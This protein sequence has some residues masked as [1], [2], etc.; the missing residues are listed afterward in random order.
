MISSAST[1]VV[2]NVAAAA[3][4]VG[5]VAENA[6]KG[7]K[8]LSC[9]KKNAFFKGLYYRLYFYSSIYLHMYSLFIYTCI[10]LHMY[11][12][13]WWSKKKFMM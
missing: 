1:A 10:L 2:G 4:A 12:S 11:S 6:T 8:Y 9:F 5:I 13:T 3:T 7:R